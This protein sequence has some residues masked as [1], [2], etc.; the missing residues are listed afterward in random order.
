MHHAGAARA[1]PPQT[2]ELGSVGPELHVVEGRTAGF[3]AAQAEEPARSAG[4]FPACAALFQEVDQVSAPDDGRVAIADRLETGLEPM[5]HGA[6]RGSGYLGC[7]PNV[8]GA[9]P[10]DPLGRMSSVRHV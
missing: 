10:F 4:L 6:G 7:F 8:V 1:E 2:A 9:Q 3:L 5:A